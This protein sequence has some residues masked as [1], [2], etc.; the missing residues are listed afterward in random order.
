MTLSDHTGTHVDALAHFIPDTATI[1][2]MPIDL[3]WGEATVADF[4]AEQGSGKELPLTELETL[5]H[6]RKRPSLL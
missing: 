3:F 2:A 6:R 1:D 4:S 5:L